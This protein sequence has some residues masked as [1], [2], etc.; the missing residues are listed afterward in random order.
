MP[1]KF[2]LIVQK[3]Q[4]RNYSGKKKCHTT[5]AQIIVSSLGEILNV[6][7]TAYGRMHDFALF[8]STDCNLEK[9]Q[10]ILADSGYQGIAKLYP[11]A[12]TPIK[13]SKKHKLNKDDKEF[14]HHLSSQ[15]MLVENI[16]AKFKVFKV[17][18]S[19]YRNHLKRLGL[20][21]N[22]IA[23]IINRELGF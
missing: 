12:Q 6:N 8:K 3:K 19:R 20:R 21:L 9:A 7:Y 4:H 13:S 18:S 2:A 10:S 23:G 16:F 17:L 5:K 22:L 11:Q 15:R 14:N 1:L